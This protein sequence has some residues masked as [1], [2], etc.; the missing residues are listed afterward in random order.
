MGCGTRSSLRTLIHAFTTAPVLALPD[1]SK[2]FQ[3]ITDTSDFAT[4]AI[5]E[6]PDALNHWHPVAFHSKSLQPTE[7][8]YKIHDKELLAIVRALEIFRHYLEGWDNTTETDHRNLVYFFTKQKLTHQQACWS[9][10]LSRFRFIII[11]KPGTQNKSDA[12]S[13]RPDHK[14]GMALDN[15]DRIL[16]D[17][18]FFTIHATQTTAVNISGDN[19]IRQ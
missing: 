8:N 11:H 17:N 2:P 9:L 7:R 15:D 10:Y 16:L 12:L 18:R 4:G 1:H 6:Q 3:L 5:L 14:E 13:Q 19:T